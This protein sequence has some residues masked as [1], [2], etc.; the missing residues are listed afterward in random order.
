M[1]LLA[2][3]EDQITLQHLEYPLVAPAGLTGE[4][5]LREPEQLRDVSLLPRRNLDLGCQGAPPS[6][7]TPAR[8]GASSS[9]NA[10]YRPPDPRLQRPLTPSLSGSSGPAVA[11]A[12]KRAF[13]PNGVRRLFVR[14]CRVL[15][16][17]RHAPPWDKRSA[18]PTAVATG[19]QRSDIR[20][21]LVVMEAR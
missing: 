6:A 11:E 13:S 12:S 2:G 3:D 15:A 14:M 21:C 5:A 7:P 19:W 16:E 18:T 1:T 10:S 20:A 17:V 9:R 4:R 8:R